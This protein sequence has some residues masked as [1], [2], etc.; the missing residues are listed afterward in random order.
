MLRGRGIPEMRLRLHRRAAGAD[1]SLMNAINPGKLLNSKWTAIKPERKEKH[2]LVSE[3]EF[4]EA[5]SVAS[6]CIEA[7][8][9]KR[10]FSIDW[11]E[12]KDE[13]NWLYGWR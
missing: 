13:N 4:D 3:V 9:S 2:F 1:R 12:L 7:V 11:R 8:I 5:G 6:C 10:V